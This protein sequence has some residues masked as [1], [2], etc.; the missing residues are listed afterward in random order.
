MLQSPGGGGGAK[1]PQAGHH[2]TV[3]KLEQLKN[4][5]HMPK[6]GAKS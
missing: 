5:V 1:D 2:I 6:N 4:L 3:N